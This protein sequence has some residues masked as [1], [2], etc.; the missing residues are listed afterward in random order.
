MTPTDI[1]AA[2]GSARTRRIPRHV[3]LIAVDG[4][5][6]LD[7]T[8]PCDV[9]GLA[10]PDGDRY[11]L[12]VV[13]DQPMVR[14][15]SGLRITPDAD[16]AAAPGDID[17]LIVPGA[18]RDRGLNVDEHVITWI[19][20][21]GGRA[22]RV[23]SVC[24]GAFLLAQ[25]GLLHGRRATTHWAATDEL[26][27]SYPDIEV[28]AD[29]IYVR[30]GN[31][32]TSAGVTAGIDLALALVEEDLGPAAAQRVARALVLFIRRPGGQAQFSHALRLP[33]AQRANIRELQDWIIDHIDHDL[34]VGALAKRSFMSQRHFARVFS[35]ETGMTPAAY[36]EATRLERARLL[37]ESTNEQLDVIATRCG[38]G[39]PETLRRSFAR[40]LHVSPA[41]YREHFG[42]G[43][44]IR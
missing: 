13:A 20:E 10:D 12:T 35:A 37:L 38:F 27:S 4:V 33:P 22:R 23:A 32:Y 9:F 26:A 24:T 11:R 16:L 30:D 3:V 42:S 6:A 2:E 36:V 18:S 5:Q 40:H 25:A 44:P 19:R 8:G 14:C 7:L 41:A 21:A 15:S 31:V 39:T 34:S 43:T 29:P 17:T 28:L 1:V